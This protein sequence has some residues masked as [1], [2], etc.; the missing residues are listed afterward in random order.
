MKRLCKLF[1][2]NDNLGKWIVYDAESKKVS[3][4]RKFNQE[5]I[6]IPAN[7][8]EIGMLEQEVLELAHCIKIWEIELVMA[9]IPVMPQIFIPPIQETPE[10]PTWP[11]TTPWF[12]PSSMMSSGAT[13]TFNSTSMTYAD[14]TNTYSVTKDLDYRREDEDVIEGETFSKM[15]LES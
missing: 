9:D 13:V 14:T 7:L 6:E 11:G 15:N 1:W 10:W 5:G 2:K 3:E 4:L 8:L 12:S